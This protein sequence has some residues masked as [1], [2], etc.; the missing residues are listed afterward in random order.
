MTTRLSVRKASGHRPPTVVDTNDV[1]R[2]FSDFEHKRL[3]G[4][5]GEMIDWD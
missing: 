5:D 3:K 4:P 2:K 1:R